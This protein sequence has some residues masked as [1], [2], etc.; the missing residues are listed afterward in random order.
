MQLE[1]LLSALLHLY[2][3][4]R[5]S[6]HSIDCAKATTRRDGKHF[7]LAIWYDLHWSF[8]GTSRE[9]SQLL[10]QMCKID[11]YH[12]TANYSNLRTMS[13][14]WPKYIFISYLP[15]DPYFPNNEYFPRYMDS[16]NDMCQCQV[17]LWTSQGT[18][19]FVARMWRGSSTE[20]RHYT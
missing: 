1:R 7:G 15:I 3:H 14:G 16:T 19:V 5:F 6:L 9:L 18:Y 11:H 13:M 8:D 4:Y 20:L 17:C 12:T 2:L 10:G